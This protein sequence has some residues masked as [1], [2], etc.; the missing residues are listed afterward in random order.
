M[1]EK[2]NKPE[3]SFDS[4]FNYNIAVN[5][6]SKAQQFHYTAWFT[7]ELSLIHYTYAEIHIMNLT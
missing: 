3:E 6:P 1:Y 2:E 7:S 5:A 4:F